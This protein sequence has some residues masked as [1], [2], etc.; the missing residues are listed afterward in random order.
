MLT[1]PP[2]E[3]RDE[4]SLLPE[5]DPRDER[6]PDEERVLGA[7]RSVE[8]LPPEDERSVERLPP[9]EPDDERVRGSVVVVRPVV[10]EPRVLRG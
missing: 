4:R 1:L 8:R 2:E 10:A 9:E 6:S 7:A 5:D 3:P